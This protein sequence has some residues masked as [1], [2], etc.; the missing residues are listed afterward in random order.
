MSSDDFYAKERTRHA[1]FGVAVFVFSAVLVHIG[2]GGVSSLFTLDA[3]LFMA[4]GIPLS[5]LVLGA[6]GF[7]LYKGAAAVL[8]RQPPTDPSPTT[9]RLVRLLDVALKVVVVLVGWYLV[10]EAWLGLHR[11]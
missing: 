2:H 1:T 8:F 7:H 3:L 10:Q 5:A 11:P 4:I 9:V 6:F